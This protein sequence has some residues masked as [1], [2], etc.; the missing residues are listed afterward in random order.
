MHE[1]KK[2]QKNNMW[3]A[4]KPFNKQKVAV[5]FFCNENSKGK[6]FTLKTPQPV[7]KISLCTAGR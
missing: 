1:S 5:D 2:L 3:Y 7:N 6:L 4:V